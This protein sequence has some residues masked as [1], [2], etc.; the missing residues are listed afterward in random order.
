[1]QIF[2]KQQGCRCQNIVHFDLI[3]HFQV[4]SW[5]NNF[6]EEKNLYPKNIPSNDDFNS[7]KP[8]W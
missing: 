7:N 3:Y 6:T 5:W 2:E 8:Q 4:L 1:M